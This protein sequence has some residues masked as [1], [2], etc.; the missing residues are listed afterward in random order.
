MP[1]CT[2]RKV[3]SPHG[4]RPII[5]CTSAFCT[6]E[7][8][9]PPYSGGMIKPNRPN[10]RI[11]STRP[12][13][14][15]PVCSIC[16][17]TALAFSSTKLRTESCSIRSSSAMRKSIRLLLGHHWL[18][19]PPAT[20]PPR[21]LPFVIL[22]HQHDRLKNPPGNAIKEPRWLAEH[23]ASSAVEDVDRVGDEQVLFG[24]GSGDVHQTAL[25]FEF[26]LVFVVQR[27]EATIH[28]PD[29]EDRMPL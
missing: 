2:L 1:V 25:F 23:H 10:S 12:W 29:D 21:L 9:K 26:F 18:C 11:P 22:L 13:G 24:A 5:S 16:F 3:A 20:G 6:T 8:P 14:S 27:R 19:P 15:S 28:R 4:P 17:Q 7:N